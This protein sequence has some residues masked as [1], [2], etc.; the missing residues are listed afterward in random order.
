MGKLF[1]IL[2]IIG[3]VLGALIAL[4][5]LLLPSMT[6]NVSMNEATIGIVSG[7]IIF[8]ISFVPAIVGLIILLVKRKKAS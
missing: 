5:S 4:V 1:M 8:V 6:R 3:I 2:G 7:A